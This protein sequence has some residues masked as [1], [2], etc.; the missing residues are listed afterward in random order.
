MKKKGITEKQGK[1]TISRVNSNVGVDWVHIVLNDD[2][3]KIQFSIDISFE[4]F[5]KAV[6]GQGHIHCLYED[7]R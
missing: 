7:Y 4:D 1:I 2:H 5:S 3:F 6:L